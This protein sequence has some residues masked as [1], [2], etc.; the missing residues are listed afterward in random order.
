MDCAPDLRT[1][2]SVATKSGIGPLW[3]IVLLGLLAWQGWMTLTLFD[4][5]HPWQRLLDDQPILSGRH[6]LHLYHGYLGAR[7][8]RE[9]GTLCCYDPAFYAG[10]PKTPVFDSGSRPAGLFLTLA[11][12]TYRPEAYKVGLA[13]CCLVVPLLV[14]AAARGAGLG[15]GAS[16]LAVGLGLLVWWSPPCRDLLEAGE[17]DFLLAGLAALAQLGLLVRWDRRAGVGAWAALLASGCLG[18]FAQPALFCALFPLILIYYLSVGARHR[19]I[20]HL[21]LFSGLTGGVVV[22]SWWLVDWFDYWWIRAPLQAETPL[23][24]HRTFHTLWASPLW[25]E[26]AD[27]ILAGVVLGGAI[28]GVWLFNATRQRPAAR[29]LGLGAVAFLSLAIA[30][31][32]WEPLAR[33]GTPRLFV[34][35]LWFAAVPAAY[36]LAQGAAL[37]CRLAGGTWRGGA[38]TAVLL[39]AVGFAAQDPVRVFA[40]RCAGT[41]PL[42]IGLAAPDQALIEMITS[43]TTP[44]ARILWEDCCD[45]P[46]ASRWSALLP[47]LTDRAYLGGLDANA[48]IEHAY[49]GLVEQKLAG[50]PIASWRDEELRDFCHH[51]N[52]GWAVCRSP[53][54]AARFRAWLGTEPTATISGSSPVYLFELPPGS[55]VLKGRAQ[56]LHADWRHIALADV[57]PEE[58]IVILSMHYQAGLRVSPSRVQIEK[59]PDPYDPIPFVRLRVPGPVARLT[60]TWQPP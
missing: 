41:T 33:L 44:R 21:A 31:L 1:E 3:I 55:F 22:N 39:A 25:G 20:W 52:V 50:R 8:L 51:Y 11:G 54:A 53:V 9:R 42:A 15:A 12:G 58:G 28:V 10:Y 19:L 16:C 57:I 32:G 37:A 17:L 30:G 45:S 23:L 14:L 13:V 5:E 35:A 38:L 26:G 36:G 48:C 56:F 7:A 29:L 43:H 2:G 18:W 49:P 40:L 47:I 24:P 60:L 6:P 34:P 59:E 4:R 27:R 46:T